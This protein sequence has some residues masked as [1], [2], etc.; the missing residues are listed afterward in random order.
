MLTSSG[1][2]GKLMRPTRESEYQRR[3]KP[4]QGMIKHVIEESNSPTAPSANQRGHTQNNAGGEE[5]PKARK[6][7]FVAR[8]SFAVAFAQSQRP[9]AF[10]FG[11]QRHRSQLRRRYESVT[12]LWR[13][14]AAAINVAITWSR[15]SVRKRLLHLSRAR[16]TP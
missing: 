3:S 6:H 10:I 7:M 16:S 4:R 5:I 2:Q 8:R 12:S 1:G 15:P 13:S 11:H 14:H 9:Q